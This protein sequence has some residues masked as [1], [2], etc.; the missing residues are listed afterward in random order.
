MLYCRPGTGHSPRDICKLLALLDGCGMPYSLNGEFADESSRAAGHPIPPE[1]R[2]DPAD[3][4]TYDGDMVLSYGG[5]G[6]FLEC[7]KTVGMA[8]IPVLGINS[9]RLGF[10]ANINKDG[11]ATALEDIKNRRYTVRESPLLEISGGAYPADKPAFAFNELAIQRGSAPMIAVETYVDGEMVAT[12]WGDGVILST[13]AGSTAYSLSVGGPVVAPQCDCMVLSPIAPHNLTM[14]PVV[15]PD[16][17]EVQFRVNGRDRDTVSSA[18]GEILQIPHGAVLSVKRSS[19]P[20]FLAH[21]QN[22]SF[23]DTLRNKML[24]GL[25]KRDESAAE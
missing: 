25:D 5:D 19:K 14:R 13:P 15:L 8:G 17:S 12:Y 24:W 22:I 4:S 10:L 20:V 2:Y 11:L 21:L 1:S 3:P 7:V 6:T 23:Y 9:G 16:S 18:D